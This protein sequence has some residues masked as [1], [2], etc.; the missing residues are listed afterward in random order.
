M[1]NPC[2]F[3]RINRFFFKLGKT[4][5]FPFLI[6]A[7]FTDCWAGC[8]FKLSCFGEIS[9]EIWAHLTSPP[10]QLTVSSPSLCLSAGR[11]LLYYDTSVFL[12]PFSRF[13]FCFTLVSLVHNELPPAVLKHI[14][15]ISPPECH[16][17]SIYEHKV[18]KV[19]ITMATAWWRT[20]LCHAPP[21][22]V[23]EKLR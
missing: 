13:S 1:D 11:S 6:P 20:I 7:W 14:S 10:G 23:D 18:G 3:N 12:K 2:S 17:T 22:W 8:S 21:P 16:T 5:F 4:G 15:D 19:C 9:H